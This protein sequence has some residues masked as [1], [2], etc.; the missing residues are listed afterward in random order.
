MFTGHE[1]DEY[2]NNHENIQIVKI[3]NLLDFDQ[4]LFYPLKN[5]NYYAFERM[6]KKEKWKVITDW[7][8]GE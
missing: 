3:A 7:K 5:A 4:S 1:N 6:N 8:P 2:T